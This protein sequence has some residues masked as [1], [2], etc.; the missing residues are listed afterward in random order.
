MDGLRKRKRGSDSAWHD[1]HGLETL[2]RRYAAWLGSVLRKQ[3]G[4]YADASEDLVQETYVRI[5][6]YCEEDAVRHP[7]ALLKRIGVN[8]ARDHMRRHVVSGGLSTDVR[9]TNEALSEGLVHD[10][11]Q[12]Y[13]LQLEQIV[14]A[15]PPIFRDVFVLNRFSGLSYAEIAQHLGISEKTV[16]WRM[17]KALVLCSEQM[18]D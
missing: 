14:L 15:L 6:R 17:S 5:A 18:Q 8:L 1:P 3:L 4:G 2:Y 13:R 7:R 10:P 16:E 9:R 11:E 12:E